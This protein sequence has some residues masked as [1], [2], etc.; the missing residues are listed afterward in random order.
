MRAKIRYASGTPAA[1][2]AR[3]VDG[4]IENKFAKALRGTD[5]VVIDH[6]DSVNHLAYWHRVGDAAA[7]NGYPTRYM[8]GYSPTAGDTAILRW[9]DDVPIL[10]DKL[11]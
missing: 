6:V 1:S 8:A 11:A 10:E 2:L 3:W 9:I 7:N 4:T 5:L